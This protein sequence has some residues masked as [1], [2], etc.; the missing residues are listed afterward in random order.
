M[1]EQE[2]VR[3]GKINACPSCSLAT[4]TCHFQAGPCDIP[5][6]L[7]SEEGTDIGNVWWKEVV[8][9]S[10]LF[11]PKPQSPSL[12]EA[13]ERKRAKSRVHPRCR[14][15]LKRGWEVGLQH[16]AATWPPLWLPNAPAKDP[17]TP[18]STSSFTLKAE[19]CAKPVS[20]KR[21][22]QSPDFWLP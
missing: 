5:A 10:P 17:E 22:F 18:F 2:G 11:T 14:T 12:T 6:L 16:V 8:R 19:A 20:W 13:T 1:K 15:R 21:G 9:V 3:A 4:P 7:R